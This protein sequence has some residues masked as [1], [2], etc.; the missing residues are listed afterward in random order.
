MDDNTPAGFGLHSLKEYQYPHGLPPARIVAAPRFQDGPSFCEYVNSFKDEDNLMLFADAEKLAFQVI[1]DY[2]E[3]PDGPA[4]CQHRAHWQ[5]T[6]SPQW[7]I[8]FGSHDKA[9]P[10]I[11]FAEFLED[12]YRDIYS[13]GSQERPPAAIMMEVAR[14]LAAHSEVT[15]E[16]KINLSNGTAK[17]RYAEDLKTAGDLEVPAR[18][19]INIPVFFGERPAVIDC[20]L[21]FRIDK[22]KLS[23]QYKMYR[24]QE[25][26]LE[27]F[28]QAVQAV[29]DAVGSPVHLGAPA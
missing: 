21:R 23:F 29:S 17:L 15:F 28:R 4:W 5:L 22:G 25:T 16:S 20:I 7:L 27:A 9:I 3:P 19:S 18:F 24:P 2:H 10:Q 26:K 8:W 14:E 11:T 6:L 12:N 1:L 13:D